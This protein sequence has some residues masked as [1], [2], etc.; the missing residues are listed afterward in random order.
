MALTLKK[1]F[2]EREEIMSYK[3]N[4]YEGTIMGAVMGLTYFMFPE[5]N[6]FY[7]FIISA[8]VVRGVTGI[9]AFKLK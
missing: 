8:L 6:W 1:N 7:I 9:I 4:S 5:A 3:I 2:D